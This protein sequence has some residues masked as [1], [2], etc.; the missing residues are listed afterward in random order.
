MERWW[1]GPGKVLGHNGQKVPVKYGSSYVWVHPYILALE[2]N[3][4][5]TDNKVS[6]TLTAKDSMH[7]QPEKRNSRNFDEDTDEELNSQENKI[8]TEKWIGQV[9]Q[10]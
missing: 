3:H 8:T 2:R 10:W 1:R 6:A 7:K 9:I 4:N 5:K